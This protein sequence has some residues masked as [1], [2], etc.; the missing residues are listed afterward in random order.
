VAQSVQSVQFWVN[1]FQPKAAAMG[2]NSDALA[3]D[4]RESWLHVHALSG[5]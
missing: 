1:A 5:I 4:L 3:G 2:R